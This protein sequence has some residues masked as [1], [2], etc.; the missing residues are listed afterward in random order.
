MPFLKSMDPVEGRYLATRAMLPRWRGFVNEAEDANMSAWD[1]VLAISDL[2]YCM[3]QTLME[4]GGRVFKNVPTLYD[5]TRVSERLFYLPQAVNYLFT[6]LCFHQSS[7]ST[8]LYFRLTFEFALTYG[9][10]FT[11]V[12][13]LRQSYKFLSKLASELKGNFHE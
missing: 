4:E 8:S 10:C 6:T 11:R 7:W 12:F 1:A 2:A 13:Y 5:F 9:G 3:T